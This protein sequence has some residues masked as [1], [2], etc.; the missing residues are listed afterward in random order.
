MSLLGFAS[1]LLLVA[2]AHGIEHRNVSAV[3]SLNNGGVG[4]RSPLLVGLTLIQTAAAKGA[5]TALL[6]P[7]VN[8]HS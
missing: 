7:L 4:S 2:W 8:F 6:L 5:G 3:A 1:L